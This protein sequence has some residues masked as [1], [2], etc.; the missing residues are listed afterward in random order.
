MRSICRTCLY[1]V[2]GRDVTKFTFEFDK[3]QTSNVF[4][5][6]KIRRIFSRTRRRIRTSGLHDW[7][8]RPPEQPIEQ[9][10]VS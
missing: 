7:N 10:R 8:H 3:V 9:M 6:F 2:T 4:S 5:R 1:F